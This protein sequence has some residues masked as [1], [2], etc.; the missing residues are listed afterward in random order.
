MR[1]SGGIALEA[2]S[3]P[4]PDCLISSGVAVRGQPVSGSADSTQARLSDFRRSGHGRR[5]RRRRRRPPPAKYSLS[6]RLGLSCSD[7]N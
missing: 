3:R 4:G 2:G 6:D 7:S 5:R 1:R